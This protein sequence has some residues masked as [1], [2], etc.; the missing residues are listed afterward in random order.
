[1]N[2]IEIEPHFWE[3]YQDQEQLYLSVSVDNSAVT[4]NWDLHLTAQQTESYQRQGREYIV[5]WAKQ[6]VAAV[7]RGDFSF[8]QTHEASSAEKAA[9]LTAFKQWR[10]AQQSD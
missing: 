1:M 6:I 3:L 4:Y 2:L 9:I 7:F 8:V 10:I 5:D